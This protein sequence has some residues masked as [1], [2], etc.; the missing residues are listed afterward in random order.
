MNKITGT[1][2]QKKTI[3]TC[4]SIG[5]IHHMEVVNAPETEDISEKN[6]T[7]VVATNA[8]ETPST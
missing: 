4:T 8:P 5:S 1:T 7:A 3:R 6:T 2:I